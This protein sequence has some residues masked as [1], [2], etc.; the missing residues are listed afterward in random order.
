MNKLEKSEKLFEQACRIIPRGVNSPVRA[1]GQVGG[2]PVFVQK[3]DG[4]YIYDVDGNRYLDYCQSWG[5]SIL[6]HAHPKVVEAVKKQA[7]LGTSF[8][9][10][11]EAEI[12]LAEILTENQ[13][14]VEMV[15]CVSSGTE[16]VMSAL[17]LA[18]G[19]TGRK[20]VL[21]FDG[22][23]HGH[24]DYLLVKAG[25]GLATLGLPGS[26][27]VTEENVKHTY[28]VKLNDTEAVDQV[29]AEHGDDIACI[30][31]EGIPANNGLLVQA[32]EFMKHLEQTAHKHGA[33]LVVDE[34]IT[35]FRVGL[36]GAV[37]LYQLNADIVM[38]GKVIGGGLP[39]GAFGARADIME[40][41]APLGPV[42]QAG[43]L[44]GNPLAM[45]SGVAV[46][47]ELIKYDAFSELE[48]KGAHFEHGLREII[49]EHDLPM[50]LS[51]AGSV[52]WLSLDGGDPPKRASEI[53]SESIK[54][55]SV[56]FH[57][58]LEKGFYFAPSGYE[59]GFMTTAHTKEMID[60][61]LTAM[62][63]VLPK[64]F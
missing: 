63:D 33:L 1:F 3:G 4:A 62:S 29:F 42:Y 24:V 22:G 12:K 21:K 37:G 26:A 8:G 20:G 11:T 7:E 13:P 39:V 64:I 2:S 23:Y 57:R 44:S 43:T 48:E 32:P 51:R 31:V 41:I 15:R 18:R 40:K 5:A 49:S 60:D 38:L 9:I 14:A 58:M 46:L 6:G 54:R 10:P 56:F 36:Q 61:T 27:G 53:S 35:G 45:A 59:V 30:L 55:Y 52:F 47:N 19:F 17:R 34:V 25:S 28:S 16:A 50:N